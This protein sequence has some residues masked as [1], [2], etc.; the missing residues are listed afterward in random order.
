LYF[1]SGR[2]GGFGGLDLWVTHKNGDA[3]GEPVNLG[4]QVNSVV[5]ENRPFVSADGKQLWFDAPSRIGRPGPAIYMSLL[6]A[7][8]SWG[9]PQE[10]VSNFAGE[11][12]LSADGKTLYFVHHYYTST[13]DR[14]L[15][16]DIYVSIHP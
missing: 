2:P 15:E 14:M 12:N 10:V 7:D 1:A 11:P 16:A 4:Q 9:S 8:G 3:W 13:V 6:Q 5:D